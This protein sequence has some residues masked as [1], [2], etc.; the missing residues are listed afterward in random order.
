[1]PEDTM[2]RLLVVAVI[3]CVLVWLFEVLIAPGLLR[4]LF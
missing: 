3:A 2:R 4:R 1:M